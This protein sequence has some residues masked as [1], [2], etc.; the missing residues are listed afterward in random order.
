MA[1]G[2]LL[3]R[4]RGGA[5]LRGRGPAT[6]RAGVPALRARRAGTAL[7][8][9]DRR[10]R[11]RRRSGRRSAIV[12]TPNRD[13]K[14][15]LLSLGLD[16]TE[17]GRRE[18]RRRGALR[19]RG[20]A[21]AARGQVRVPPGGAPT[22]WRAG[23]RRRAADRALPRIGTGLDPAER[24]RHLSP[25]RRLHQRDEG[26]GRGKPGPGQA[27]HPAVRD[28]HGPQGPGPRDHRGRERPR[29]QA[30][31]P[32]H[33]RPPRPRVALGRARHGVGLRAG[34]RLQGG[35]RARA[36]ADAT[37]RARSSSRS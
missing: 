30:G 1:G 32:E 37:P 2:N 12:S 25:A 26:A 18:L 21:P 7:G 20:C 16:V 35:Q 6:S 14:N 33:G 15:E 31:V 13:R 5:G 22:S 9:V 8:R 28:L 27:A 23:A 4:E 19:R 29:R 3:R 11:R 17:H 24:P 10:A 34:Q 36:P